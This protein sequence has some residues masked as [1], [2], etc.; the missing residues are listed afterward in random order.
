MSIIPCNE[1]LISHVRQIEL[2][3]FSFEGKLY[4]ENTLV[5]VLNTGPVEPEV[6]G[7][8]TYRP[9]GDTILIASLAVTESHRRRGYGALLLSTV[10]KKYP[11][12]LLHVRCNNQPALSLY[13]KMGFEIIGTI[14]FYYGS[15]DGLLM[16]HNDAHTDSSR[17]SKSPTEVR[18]PSL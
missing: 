7:Y 9:S 11:R 2:E 6:V 4:Q 18:V 3:C 16:R 8:L 1:S 5:C 14:P 13:R 10:L 17:S 15:A 12:A